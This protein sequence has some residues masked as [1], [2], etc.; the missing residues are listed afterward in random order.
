MKS[1]IRNVFAIAIA[2]T[3]LLTVVATPSCQ[4]DKTNTGNVYVLDTAG[5]PLQGA[6]VR[7]YHE[8]DTS[9]SYISKPGNI[10]YEGVTDK[11]GYIQFKIKLP[12]VYTV[13]VLHP[14]DM[15]TND[16]QHIFGVLILNEPGSTDTERLQFNY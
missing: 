16:L 15:G 1:F 7:L 9:A 10:V 13:R 8:G 11:N 14:T 2:S 5:K 6:N 4:K 3:L 12:A